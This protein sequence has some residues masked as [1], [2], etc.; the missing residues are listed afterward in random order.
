[1][2]M[3][4]VE[5]N[6]LSPEYLPPKQPAAKSNAI[7]SFYFIRVMGWQNYLKIIELISIKIMGN[8]QN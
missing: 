4:N 5:N 2:R 6:F 8:M 3:K 1:M 7:F